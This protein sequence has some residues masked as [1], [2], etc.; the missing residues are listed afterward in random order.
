ME[1]CVCTATF[2]VLVSYN[3]K[4]SKTCSVS[5]R[6][7]LDV[8]ICLCVYCTHLDTITYINNYN[9]AR[10]ARDFVGEQGVGNEQQGCLSAVE[11]TH[12]HTCTHVARTCVY[13]HAH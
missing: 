8:H 4:T 1:E 13:I 12:S 3:S 9:A 7:T 6:C 5:I 11:Q 10:H 2:F